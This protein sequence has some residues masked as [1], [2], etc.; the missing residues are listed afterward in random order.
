MRIKL[1]LLS[2]ALTK[3]FILVNQNKI[4]D[5]D[6]DGWLG[7]ESETYRT[8]KNEI[9]DHFLKRSLPGESGKLQE[10]LK[11]LIKENGSNPRVGET[12]EIFMKRAVSG[13]I[14]K[15]INKLL[16]MGESELI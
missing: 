4:F 7:A 13:G 2:L 8:I 1:F 12:V 14:K 10:Y 16:N 11:E 6:K 15:D 5:F 9:A 3:F